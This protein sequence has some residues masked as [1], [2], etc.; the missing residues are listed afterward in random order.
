MSAS[1]RY[2]E[3]FKEGV[4]PVRATLTTARAPT[5]EAAE[6]LRVERGDFAANAARMDYPAIRAQGLPIGS[7]A[8]EASARHVVQLRMQRSGQRWSEAGGRAMLALR[9]CFASGR[10]PRPSEKCPH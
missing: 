9:A 10:T 8:V 1:V 7:G 2:T 3:L 6:V 5:A 4:G